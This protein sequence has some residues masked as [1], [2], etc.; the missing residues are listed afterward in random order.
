[1]MELF[2]KYLKRY[3]EI[4]TGDCAEYFIAI[5]DVERELA[6]QLLETEALGKEC[7][8]AWFERS[9]YSEAVRLRNDKNRSKI[10]LLSS[11]SVKMIDSLK[12]FVE[13]PVIPDDR[14]SLWDCLSTAFEQELDNDGKKILEVVMEHQQISVENLLTYLQACRD[15]DGC[16][17]TKL[18]TQNLYML[19]IWTTKKSVTKKYLQR[20]VKNSDPLIVEKKLMS[21]ISEGKVSLGKTLQSRVVK[22]ISRNNFHE[23]YKNV[24]YEKVEELFKGSMKNNVEAPHE[25]ME[26]QSY[27]N[28]YKYAVQE[29]EL[30]DMEILENTLMDSQKEIL[31]ES[32]QRFHAPDQDKIKDAFSGLRSHI[33]EMNF[34]E[35]KRKMMISQ[36]GDLEETFKKALEEGTCYT[37]AY[38]YH[39]AKSQKKLVEQYFQL[40]GKCISDEGIARVCT[41][42][43]FL[44]ALQNIFCVR[45]NNEIEMPFYH[46]LVGFYYIV[47]EEYY[48][49]E[50]DDFS[51]LKDDFIEDAVN[52]L[53]DKEQLDFPVRYMLWDKELYQLDYTSLQ[54]WQEKVVFTKMDAHMTQS[55]VNVR[56]LNDDLMDYI[57]RQKYL[58]EI[59]VTVVDI[60]D[61]REIVSM[62]EKLRKIA[63]SRQSVVNKVILNIVSSKEEELKNQL[64][65]RMEMDIDYPQVLFRF[66]RELYIQDG[67]Y[68]LKK[69][70]HDSDLIFLADSNILYQL[71]R[72]VPWKGDANWLRVQFGQ[73]SLEDMKE[74]YVTGLRNEAE[75]LWDSL[76][77]IEREE[78]AKIACW[79]TQ[80]MKQTILSE[81]RQAVREDPTLTVVVI[82]SNPQL[83]Q[84]IYHI[85]GFQVRKC[86]IPGQEML[87]VNFHQGSTRKLLKQGGKARVRI[88]LKPFLEELL[89]IQEMRSILYAGDEEAEDPCLTIRY[90]DGQFSFQCELGVTDEPNSDKER[91]KHYRKLAKDILKLSEK[92]RAFREKWITML[93]EHADN[94]ESALMVDYMK[95]HDFEEICWD[96]REKQYQPVQNELTDS[97]D[98][99]AFQSMLDFIRHLAAIDDYSVNCFSALYR[100]EMLK[101][102]MEADDTTGFL[103]ADVRQKMNQLDFRME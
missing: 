29:Q 1:M 30:M 101:G 18:M 78:E 45:K 67:H 63:E 66:T 21:G 17:R 82:S 84:N 46:P 77:H 3:V 79:N 25:K 34:S 11:D 54:E 4:L 44:N 9:D 16:F 68:D 76:H 94:Y 42:T 38:L 91:E 40:L 36:I 27:E 88:S 59:R 52:A 74:M 102:C 50:R 22:W 73:L 37:P 57:K 13:Y 61:I 96:Y 100:K 48:R 97:I 19:D 39:Y 23:I 41:G 26:E 70:I 24:P 60:N 93:Y 90:K 51:L 31:E 81:I 103:E 10:I 28:S 72:L 99:L 65:D 55:W 83:L 20:M 62:V 92:N 33:C 75:I 95:R 7:S 15:K 69:I 80:E 2:E 32:C 6:R 35:K 14:D 43:G 64:R 47:L 12:D 53:M 85:E 86:V 71:P 49:N 5:V 8:L 89:G 87:M 98:V 56:L 58:P